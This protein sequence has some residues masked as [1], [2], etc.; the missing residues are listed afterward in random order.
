MTWAGAGLV[1][2][3]GE[4][5]SYSETDLGSG[6]ERGP[7]S[8]AFAEWAGGSWVGRSAVVGAVELAAGSFGCHLLGWR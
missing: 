1:A 2:S 5:A 7:A 4:L 3:L 8:C 6:L